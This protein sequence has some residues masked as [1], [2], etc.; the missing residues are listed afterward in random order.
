[1]PVLTH[2]GIVGYLLAKLVFTAEPDEAEEAVGA[3]RGAVR[4]RG[5]F[6]PLLQSAI[7]FTETKTLDLDALRNG[8]RDA[9]TSASATSWSTR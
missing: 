3:G 9:S 4:R 7:N 8:I 5:L 6:L 1:M 2:E